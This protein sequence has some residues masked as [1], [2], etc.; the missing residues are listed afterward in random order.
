MT[1]RLLSSQS[2]AIK[3]V[4]SPLPR[5]AGDKVLGHVE[6][7]IQRAL[8]DKIEQLRVKLRG[9]VF[10]CVLLYFYMHPPLNALV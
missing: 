10:T 1:T 2:D 5:I 6:F 9:V 3:L 4:F 8:D 7:D